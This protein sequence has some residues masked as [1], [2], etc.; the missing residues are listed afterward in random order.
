[1]HKPSAAARIAGNFAKVV[2]TPQ[3]DGRLQHVQQLQFTD[4]ATAEKI[5]LTLIQEVYAAD[6]IKIEL[7][8]SPVSLNSIHGFLT[9]ADGRRFFFKTHTETD[10]VIAEY[11]RAQ[12]IA[13][14]GYPVIQPLFQSSTVGKQLLVYECVDDPSVFDVAWA[15]ENRQ[16]TDPTLLNSLT[17]AQASEDNA[18]FQRYQESLHWQ[19]A[20]AASE[21]PIHQ[22]FHHRLTGG[23]YTRFYDDAEISLPGLSLRYDD[24]RQRRWQINGQEYD[25]T[26]SGI[27]SRCLDLLAPAQAGPAIVGH[28]DAHNGNVFLQSTPSPRLLYFDPAFAGPHHPLLDLAKPFFHNVFAMWMYFPHEMRQRLDVRLYQNN[29]SLTVTYK[30][31]LPAVREMFFRSKLE[32]VLLPTLRDL[33]QRGWLRESWRAFF[34]AALACCPLLTLNLADRTR[35]PPEIALLGFAMTVEMGADSSE[36]RSYIDNAL[37][38]VEASLS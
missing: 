24:L 27:V 4:H 8:P 22:L 21:A 7:R 29:D 25:D 34:K 28:G 1:M 26:L 31:S 11:Y 3:N 33:S 23:R 30:N 5:M 38:V 15:T 17:Q 9:H 37:D 20:G 16:E 2:D 13:D 14:A 10:T 35:F 32:K 18:L 6:V 19:D 36:R 12:Q